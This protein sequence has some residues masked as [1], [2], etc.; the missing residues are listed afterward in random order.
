MTIRGVAF[1]VNDPFQY[2]NATNNQPVMMESKIMVNIQ[3]KDNAIIKISNSFLSTFH[4]QYPIII[5]VEQKMLN[6]FLL[7]FWYC[8]TFCNYNTA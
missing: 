2:T 3:K 6:I 1:G 8:S 7:K 5:G 4:V